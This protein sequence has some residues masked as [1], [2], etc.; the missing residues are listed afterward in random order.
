MITVQTVT[1]LLRSG[2][3]MEPELSFKYLPS[4]TEDIYKSSVLGVNPI[5][6]ILSV[7]SFTNAAWSG[8]YA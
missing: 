3:F 6:D 8:R 1:I 7:V 5:T 4:L 2:Q